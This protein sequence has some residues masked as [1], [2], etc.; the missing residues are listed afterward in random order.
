VKLENDDWQCVECG[1]IRRVELEDKNRE[2][3]KTFPTVAVAEDKKSRL[4]G[5]GAKP[6]DLEIKQVK[7]EPGEVP[8][9]TDDSKSAES[10]ESEA[11]ENTTEDTGQES[12]DSTGGTESPEQPEFVG[13]DEPDEEPKAVEHIGTED[14]IHAENLNKAGSLPQI[15]PVEEKARSVIQ[16]LDEADMT[17]LVWDPSANGKN[18]PYKP[19]RLPYD[20]PEPSAEAFDMFATI[21]EGSQDVRYSVVDVEFT[22]G[23]Q[24]LGCTVTIAKETPNGTKRLVGVKTRTNTNKDHWRERLYSKARRNALKQDIP[25]TWVSTLLRQYKSMDA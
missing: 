21:I 3:T 4:R 16:N 9:P 17:R 25:P 19:S 18:V 22:E 7:H 14:E 15:T 1:E 10:D 8:E 5:L 13:R 6:E 23:D 20:R 24:T 11:K 2:N 12:N